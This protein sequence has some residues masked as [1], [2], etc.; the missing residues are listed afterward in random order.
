MFGVAEQTYVTASLTIVVS[1]IIGS[2]LHSI[3]TTSVGIVITI[4]Y[5]AF[6][7]TVASLKY[8][9]YIYI[10]RKQIPHCLMVTQVALL[11]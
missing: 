7:P 8:N 11:S 4:I 9:C 1:E 10:P 6:I 3:I 5:T 2:Q